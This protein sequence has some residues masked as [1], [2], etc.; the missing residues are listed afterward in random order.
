MLT[1]DLP[2]AWMTRE[3]DSEPG[4]DVLAGAALITASV[5]FLSL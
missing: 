4:V 3:E 1:E 5:V 2:A